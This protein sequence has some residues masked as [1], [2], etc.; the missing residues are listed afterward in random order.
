MQLP[1]MRPWFSLRARQVSQ[2]QAG[3]ALRVRRSARAAALAV[4]RG[5]SPVKRLADADA[6]RGDVH[7]PTGPIESTSS[8]MEFLTTEKIAALR[9]ATTRDNEPSALRCEVKPL[10]QAADDHR[11]A[12]A[13]LVK[14]SGRCFSCLLR[15]N[16]RMTR[17]LRA[18]IR[19]TGLKHDLKLA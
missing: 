18:M 8:P 3:A 9:A 13:V 19:D 4:V 6:E 7:G 16:V 12:A 2:R 17:R 11:A 1:G 10:F 15:A 5:K 14:Y